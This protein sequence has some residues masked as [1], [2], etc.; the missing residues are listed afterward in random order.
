MF[1]PEIK[2]ILLKQESQMIYEVHKKGV[3]G[4]THEVKRA[5]QKRVYFPLPSTPVSI[6][7]IQQLFKGYNEVSNMVYYW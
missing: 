7:S 2:I 5:S 1:G 4:Q 6:E 3:R